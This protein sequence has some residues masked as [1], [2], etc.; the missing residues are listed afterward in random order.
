MCLGKERKGGKTPKKIIFEE[1]SFDERS[2]LLRAF[3][4]DIDSDGYIIDNTGS[5]IPSKET[6]SKFL[7][8]ADSTLI[9][10]SLEVIDGTPT[11]ISKF[12]R[13]KVEV[14]EQSTC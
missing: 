3:D 13:E 1:L 5:K 9:P 10:G 6:P 12:I 4:Y 7:K 11:S 8:V 2:L 14:G